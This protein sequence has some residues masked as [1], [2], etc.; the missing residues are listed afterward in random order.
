[1]CMTYCSFYH[2]PTGTKYWLT[3]IPHDIYRP[4]VVSPNGAESAQESTLTFARRTAQWLIINAGLY[5]SSAFGGTN[6]PEGIVIQNGEVVQNKPVNTHPGSM[7]LVID[8]E[9]NLNHADANADAV[10]LVR[11]GIQHAVCGFMPIIIK[12]QCVSAERWP[13]V[14]H[15]ARP[16]ARQVIGQ[17]ANGDY[18]IITTEGCPTGD[19]SA[20]LTIEQVQEICTEHE[21][22]YAYNLDGGTSTA[23]VF[24]GTQ[25]NPCYKTEVGRIVPTYI[26]FVTVPMHLTTTAV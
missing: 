17:R 20:G 18:C 3:V 2:Q 4:E 22:W 8:T 5:D 12:G 26:R 23:T 14:G 9:G 25:I 10:E 15:F 1:M 21:L 6:R 24:N 7:P 13:K 11:S 19:N 16:H